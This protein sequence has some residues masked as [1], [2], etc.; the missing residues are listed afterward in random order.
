VGTAYWQLSIFYH[1]LAMGGGNAGIPVAG[2][3]DI[4]YGPAGYKGLIKEPRIFALACFASIG[5][6]LFGY[7]QGV[8]SG[9]LV[10]DSFAKHFPML[11]DNAT[12]QGWL[13]SIMTLGAMF[14]AFVNGPISDRLS[15]RWSILY[16]NIIF[17]IGSVIQ[18]AAENIVMLFVGRVVFG[19][20]VGML[21]MVVPLYLSELAPPNIRGALVALQQLSITLGIMCSFWINYGTQY[22]GGTGDGQS[23]AAWRTPFALQCLPSAILA[24]GTFFLPYSPRWLLN[25]GTSCLSYIYPRITH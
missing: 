19:C 8:I 17:L 24:I 5:G 10:M 13:V 3:H 14:G 22:I 15:R 20:A 11:T 1:S 25:Q 4:A 12:L 21:A 23:Q 16:A 9:V 2:T 6:L 7:D 18:C